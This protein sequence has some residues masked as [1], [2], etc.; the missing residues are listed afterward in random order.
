M[1]RTCG[2]HVGACCTS[3]TCSGSMSIADFSR[4]RRARTPTCFPPRDQRLLRMLIGSL[5][6]GAVDKDTSLREG[7]ILLWK[8]PQVCAELRELLA[9]LAN[10][11]D[12]VALPLSTHPEVPLAI[13]GRYTRVEI[14]AAFGLGE[15]AKVVPWQTGCYWVPMPGPTCSRSRSTRRPG[16]FHRRPAIVTMQSVL[17]SSTGRVSRLHERIVKPDAGISAMSAMEVA[18]CFSRVVVVMSGRSI[19]LAPRRT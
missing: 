18:S 1:R 11:I 19:S 13:H 3:M 7:T 9:V 4:S 8:H 12:H 14:L 10:R 2:E 5:V 15:G 17:T 6:G 16:I